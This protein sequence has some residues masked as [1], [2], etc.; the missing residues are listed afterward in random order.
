MRRAHFQA[1]SDGIP[2]ALKSSEYFLDMLSELE[3]SLHKLALLVQFARAAA[4]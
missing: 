4:R 1:V 3:S 2:A